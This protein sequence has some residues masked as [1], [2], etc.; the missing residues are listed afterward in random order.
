LGESWKNQEAAIYMLLGQCVVTPC[1]D[2]K[3]LGPIFERILFLRIFGDKV[4]TSKRP[5]HLLGT[6]CQCTIDQLVASYGVGPSK[7]YP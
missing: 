1:M 2:H 4:A 7:G 6:P 5:C 3:T